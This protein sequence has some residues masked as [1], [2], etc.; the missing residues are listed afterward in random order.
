MVAVVVVVAIMV[1]V[2]EVVVVATNAQMSDE[3][4]SSGAE[5]KQRC[6]EYAGVSGP[7]SES[8]A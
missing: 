2:V 7:V 4:S 8:R 5:V 1:L 3:A 6:S